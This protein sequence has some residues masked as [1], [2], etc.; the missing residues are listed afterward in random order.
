MVLDAYKLYKATSS[1]VYPLKP[2]SE[3][4]NLLRSIQNVV[5]K[6]DGSQI[7]KFNGIF[8]HFPTMFSTLH[9]D[10]VSFQ[11]HYVAFKSDLLV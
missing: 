4:H 2:F 11:Q 8:F 1:T 9:Y 6:K 5:I 3:M 10:I 7:V